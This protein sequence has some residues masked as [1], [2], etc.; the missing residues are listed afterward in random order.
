MENIKHQLLQY[1]DLTRA[2][3]EELERYVQDHPRWQPALREAQAFHELLAAAR[4]AGDESVSADALSAYILSQALGE[5]P[6]AETQTQYDRIEAELAKEPALALQAEEM[7]QALRGL[8]EAAADPV[9]QF[10]RLA[11]RTLATPHAADRRPT[12]PPRGAR[13][14]FPRVALLAAVAVVALYGALALV[15]RAT[16]PERARLAD[17]GTVA[18]SY[19]GLRLRSS[20][21][22]NRA[23][24]DLA[25]ALDEL[26]AARSSVLGLFPAYDDGRL[27]EVAATLRRVVD[28]SGPES[29]EGLDALY[30]LGTIRLYQGQDEEAAWAFQSVI[31]M[32]GPQ[33]SSAR[34]MLDF[35][36][37]QGR[38]DG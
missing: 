16:L 12:R 26:E 15:S 14:R 34:R 5:S 6:S 20:G 28:T 31:A 11:G 19:E 25:S 23:A 4:A 7:R 3:R 29:W 22:A 37:E 33:A 24:D 35:L 36:Q 8:V 13:W 10:E 32:D 38:L 27:N 1:G 2:E 18:S 17:L 9:E 21:P 30:V